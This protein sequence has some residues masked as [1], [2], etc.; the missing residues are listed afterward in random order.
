MKIA[1][2]NKIKI[3]DTI[4]ISALAHEIKFEDGNV[5]PPNPDLANDIFCAE[6]VTDWDEGHSIWGKE[7]PHGLQYKTPRYEPSSKGRKFLQ[8]YVLCAKEKT[9][10]VTAI[11][12]AQAFGKGTAAP[13]TTTETAR[14]HPSQKIVLKY[15]WHAY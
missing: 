2:L 13:V 6:E 8:E 11:I 12:G 10:I 7:E 1:E 5:L 9:V 15:R 3:D 4:F 14:K